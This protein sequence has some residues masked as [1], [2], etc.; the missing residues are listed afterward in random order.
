MEQ[1]ILVSL[2]KYANA[3]NLLHVVPQT[4]LHKSG[5]KSFVKEFESEIKCLP[6]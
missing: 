1:Y 2:T 4:S 5:F 3:L 6:L